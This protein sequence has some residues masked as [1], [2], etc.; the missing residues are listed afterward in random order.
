MYHCVAALTTYMFILK[1]LYLVRV[2]VVIEPAEI[3]KI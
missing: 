3:L 2:A 1:Y